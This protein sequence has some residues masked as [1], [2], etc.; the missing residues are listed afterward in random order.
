MPIRRTLV[1]D[2]ATTGRW[3]FRLDDL[4]PT[5]PHIARLAYI[6]MDNGELLADESM[7]V[8]PE[9]GWV[10]ETEAIAQ[11]NITPELATENGINLRV[12][13]LTFADQLRKA[14]VLVAFNSD[15]HLRVLERTCR[16][17]TGEELLADE[18]QL[19][20]CAMRQATDIVCKPRP[21]TDGYS[22]P[23][24]TEAY[25]HFSGM[26]LPK[27]LDP[28]EQGYLQANAVL[29]IW[30]GILDVHPALISAD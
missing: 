9:P 30:R 21:G 16:D 13:W 4:D 15:F 23:K 8:V 29:D 7:L 26:E 28:I 1:F 14:E 17:A 24:M 27:T 18:H 2:T 22:W 19:I 3:K 20:E 25:H 5:Q 12:A 6:V 10:Y 11:H